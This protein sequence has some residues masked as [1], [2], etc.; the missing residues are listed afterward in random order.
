MEREIILLQASAKAVNL[1]VSCELIKQ[2]N[3]PENLW[4][5]SIV[6]SI[7]DFCAYIIFEIVSS[8][9]NDGFGFPS[10]LPRKLTQ[11]SL[12]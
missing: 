11:Q 2:E 9:I 4:D 12:C 6:L 8:S 3:N 7:V 5:F 10:P 1:I